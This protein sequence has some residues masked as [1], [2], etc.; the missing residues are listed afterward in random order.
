MVSLEAVDLS[1]EPGWRELVR[2]PGRRN[3]SYVSGDPHTDRIRVRYYVD[4]ATD[5]KVAKAVFGPGAEGPPGYAHGGSIAA[6]LDEAMGSHLWYRGHPVLLARFELSY[7]ASVPQ[8]VPVVVRPRLVSHR[9]RKI[10]A[11]GA[12]EGLDGTVYCESTAL[13][14]VMD[15]ARREAF[16]SKVE[17]LGL[18][19]PAQY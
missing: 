7:R 8:G 11:A 2:D 3:T 19:T 10:E 1:P 6:L 12:I 15:D 13:F 9:G 18:V 16:E 17:A 5:T 14:V 4:E